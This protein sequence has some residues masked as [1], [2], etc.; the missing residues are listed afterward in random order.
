MRC[1]ALFWFFMLSAIWLHGETVMVYVENSVAEEV[2]GP[3]ADEQIDYYRSAIEAGII[4]VLFEAGHIAYNL[5]P[6]AE[7]RIEIDGESRQWLRVMAANG[8]ASHLVWVRFGF[9]PNRDLKSRA[10]TVGY[11]FIDIAL[12]DV[13]LS[14]EVEIADFASAGVGPARLYFDIGQSI[15]NKLLQVD[16]QPR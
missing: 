2:D 1:I 6:E 8:G 4:D 5:L 16:W 11:G 14:G 10:S 13:L 12:P 15:A 3:E 9:D 7:T